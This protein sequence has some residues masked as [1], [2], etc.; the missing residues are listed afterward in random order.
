MEKQVILSDPAALVGADLKKAYNAV[1]AEKV[2]F[3]KYFSFFDISCV[4][5]S[6]WCRGQVQEEGRHREADQ[7]HPQAQ[8][9]DSH[10]QEHQDTGG[11][12]GVPGQ[13]S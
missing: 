5:E 13:G 6:G 10:R 12:D 11:G 4:V 1:K 8:D 9:P 2:K 3:L 7:E